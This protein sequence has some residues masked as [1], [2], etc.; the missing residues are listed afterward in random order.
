MADV[1]GLTSAVV[2][3]VPIPEAGGT[4]FKGGSTTFSFTHT[5]VMKS[6]S[7]RTPIP[8]QEHFRQIH[9]IGWSLSSNAAISSGR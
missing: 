2:G 8:L 5:G 4:V 1:E 7:P 6:Q 9:A 3:D